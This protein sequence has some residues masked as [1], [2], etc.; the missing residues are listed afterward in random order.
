MAGSSA[1]E[2]SSIP[3]PPSAG[4]RAK[5][6]P[7]GC[8]APATRSRPSHPEPHPDAVALASLTRIMRVAASGAAA[9]SAS[10]QLV[11]LVDEGVDDHH[12][13]EDDEDAKRPQCRCGAWAQCSSRHGSGGFDHELVALEIHDQLVIKALPWPE[14]LLLDGRAVVHFVGGRLCPHEPMIWVVI[15]KESMP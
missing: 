9:T 5:S 14:I 4:G 8:P 3:T 11:Q 12:A 7:G 10:S 2:P 1:S 13:D 15:R 6:S